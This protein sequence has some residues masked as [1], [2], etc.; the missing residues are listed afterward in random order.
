[1]MMVV[2]TAHW[3]SNSYRARPSVKAGVIRFDCLTGIDL[4]DRARFPIPSSPP[5]RAVSLSPRQPLGLELAH[6]AVLLVMSHA[7]VEDGAVA[8][9]AGKHQSIK[10][11]KKHSFKFSLIDCTFKVI[12]TDLVASSPTVSRSH[13]S[14][15][16]RLACALSTTRAVLTSS[17]PLVTWASP[18][19]MRWM[20]RDLST[21]RHT[22]WRR[23]SSE[24]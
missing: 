14:A 1:M 22:R 23:G 5:L 3:T 12:F 11:E 6:G 24:F 16:M 7:F 20:G 9:T 2:F 19:L 17:V 4:L 15:K 18:W 21:R 10:P 13:R 8:R